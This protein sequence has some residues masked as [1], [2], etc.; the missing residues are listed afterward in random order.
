M[1]KWYIVIAV[2]VSLA[3][4]TICKVNEIP[5]EPES[6]EIKLMRI[7]TELRHNGIRDN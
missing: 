2:A 1:L 7:E 3:T 5:P 4:I 6:N